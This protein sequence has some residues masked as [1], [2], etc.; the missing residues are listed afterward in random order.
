MGEAIFRFVYGTNIRFGLLNA[1]PHPGNYLFHDNGRVTF[2]DFGCVKRFG[3]EQV[4]AI[5]AIARACIRADVLGTWRACVEGGFCRSTDPVTPEEVYE[6][7][8]GSWEL[9]WAEQPFTVTPQCAARWIE[10]KYSPTGPS[11]NAFRYFTS[12]PEY[13][14]MGRI[15]MSAASLIAELRATNYWGSIAAEFF[16]SAAPVTVLGKLDQAFFASRKAAANGA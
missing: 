9:F 15:E 1:D 16:E 11:A 7:W 14:T 6:F 12:P 3:D 5:H 4:N 8:R 13:V 2:L 10:H